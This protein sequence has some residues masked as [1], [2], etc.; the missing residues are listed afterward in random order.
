MFLHAVQTF[1]G[2]PEEIFPFFADARNLERLTPAFLKFRIL[3]EMPVEM[4]EGALID[5]SLRLNG[6][7]VRW[8]SEIL[9][10]NPG[11]KFID[12]QVRGPYRKWVHEH[13]FV[14]LGNHTEVHDRV[15][16]EVPGPAFLERNFVRPRLEQIFRYRAEVLRWHHREAAPAGFT[17]SETRP[18][19]V[20][21]APLREGIA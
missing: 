5:Y 18:A 1:Q 8:R 11:K 20:P 2:A 4:R 6:I 15:E 13:I 19:I 17:I 12:R 10:W 16:Y 21:K 7:P 9:E 3:S 14:G